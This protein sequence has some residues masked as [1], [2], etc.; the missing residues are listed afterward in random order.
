MTNKGKIANLEKKV[1]D[2][3]VSFCN[4]VVKTTDAQD[5]VEKLQVALFQSLEREKK[6]KVLLREFMER[7]KEKQIG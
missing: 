1:E 2:L 5:M 7:E 4:Q 3:S 6:W